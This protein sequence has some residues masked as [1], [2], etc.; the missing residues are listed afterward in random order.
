M[1]KKSPLS[2]AQWKEIEKRLLAGEGSRALS[3]A[4]GVP[5]STIRFRLSAHTAQVKKVANQVIEAEQNFYA[6]PVAAQISA[7]T[8]IN[9]LRSISIHLA[10]AARYGAMTAHKL[11]GIANQQVEMID[12]TDLSPDSK[13][14]ETLRTVAALTEVANKSSQT[15]INLLS[16]NKEIVQK[17]TD[18]APE[19][20]AA[21]LDD[22]TKAAKLAGLLALAKAKAES[23]AAAG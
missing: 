23:H 16:A 15:G 1:A 13:S 8:L 4:Y 6:L 21:A 22:K 9:E 3:R 14:M 7:Q 17:A 11:S 12:D 2:D 18:Q 19:S 10:S 5:E 20:K